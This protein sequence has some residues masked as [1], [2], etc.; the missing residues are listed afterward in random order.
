MASLGDNPLWSKVS[1]DTSS[2]TADVLGPSYS[3]ADN[4]RGPASMGVGSN[5]TISQLGTNANAIIQY[6]KYMI[7]TMRLV[8]IYFYYL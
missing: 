4:I 5:G 6:V 2:A 7:L 3:Y 1:S 8:Y